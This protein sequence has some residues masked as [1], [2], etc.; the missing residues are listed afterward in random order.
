[1]D[2][3]TLSAINFLLGLTILLCCGYQV[4]HQSSGSP[5]LW[6]SLSGACLLLNAGIALIADLGVQI[7]LLL[8]MLANAA[9]MSMHLCVLFGLAA[10]QQR[11]L[12]RWLYWSLVL[13]VVMLHLLPV[14]QQQFR[15]RVFVCFSVIILLNIRALGLLKP[16]KLSQLSVASRILGTALLFNLAQM[17]TRWLMYGAELMAPE[18]FTQPPLLHQ[19]GFFCMTVFASILL[20]GFVAVLVQQQHQLLLHQA[21]RDALTGLYNRHQLA[22]KITAVLNQSSRQKHQVALLLLDLD[23][24]KQINDRF[25]HSLGD[26]VLTAVAT[27]MQQHCRDY[28]L[29]FRLGG[30]E[31]LICL[32]DT[33]PQQALQK[34]EQLRLLIRQLHQQQDWPAE[35]QLSASIGWTCSN[36]QSE[37]MS[38]IEQADQ[39]L[40]RAK[41]LGRNLVIY[42]SDL[43]DL[44]THQAAQSSA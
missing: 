36:G 27:A 33:G 24:F 29:L 25:G 9:T 6:F 11:P 22:P 31:F 30:E 19:L 7:S 3:L 32:P 4:K 12:R 17:T 21:Q 35:L 34:A 28:D 8:P 37:V 26:K 16:L 43:Q 41:Q 1:M 38:L 2:L 5:W 40:Y 23:H 13:T 10:W 18:R 14:M 39:A 44:P 42:H 15:L 20:A